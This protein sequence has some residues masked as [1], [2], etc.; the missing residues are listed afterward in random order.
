[1]LQRYLGAASPVVGRRADEVL[2]RPRQRLGPPWTKD[3]R[4][5][6]AAT[7]LGRS[8]LPHGSTEP[9]GDREKALRD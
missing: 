9:N 5:A 7:I 4:A 8:R 6:L 3:H 2:H 1:M